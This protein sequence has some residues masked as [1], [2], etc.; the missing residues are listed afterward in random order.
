MASGLHYVV[1]QLFKSF[2]LNM[3][4]AVHFARVCVAQLGNRSC[5]NCNVATNARINSLILLSAFN[6]IEGGILLHSDHQLQ[7]QPKLT[8]V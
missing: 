5:S 8:C 4:A 2:A 6:C 3:S 7:S 1:M